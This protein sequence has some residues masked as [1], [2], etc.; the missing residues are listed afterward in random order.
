MRS[1]A[2]IALISTVGCGSKP[3]K[4]TTTSTSSTTSSQEIVTPR[5]ESAGTEPTKTEVAIVPGSG[6]RCDMVPTSDLSI[7]GLLDDWRDKHVLTRVGSPADGSVEVRCA[8][9]GKAIAFALDIKDDR[10]IRVKGGKEDHVTLSLAAGARPVVVD[11]Y[12]G[13]SMA[14]PKITKPAR[15]E[16]AD[17]L[18]PK[19]F[20]IEVAIPAGAIPDF[21]PATPSFALDLVFHDS[22]AAT[23]GDST[24][25]QIK[26]PIELGDR[27]DLF[28]DF[29]T[30]VRLRKTDIK[31]DTLVELEAEHKG[32]E[33]L[34]AGGTVIGVL[35]EQFAYV[36]LPA[37]SPDD[38][39]KVELLPLGNKGQQIVSAIVRQS[40]NG[41]SRDLLMLWTVWS[42]QLQPL[43]NIEVKKEMGGNVL[44][45]TWK[46]VKGKKGPEL[47]VEPKPAIGF[48]AETFNEIPAG[49][50]DSIILPWDPERAGVAYTLK[51]VEIERRDL[52]K[53]KKR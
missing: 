20:S 3:A 53:K 7:D 44:E 36:T 43:V 34:V 21:S 10:L 8:W 12:P 22:D 4:P 6:N 31:L 15:V 13:N 26:Q 27:K 38:V 5:T 49:D 40:G 46:L 50:S 45:A 24:P 18:Q 52:P 29:L 1:I 41:G 23:G 33:R 42:G 39:K 25:V 30:T 14:K 2:A 16:A 47:V 28:E 9:D 11:V 48:T 19:G 37:A 17:S 35:T 51:G 32:K